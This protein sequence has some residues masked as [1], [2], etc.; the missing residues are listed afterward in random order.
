MKRKIKLD[1]KV[2]VIVINRISKYKIL[3]LNLKINNNNSSN[4][5]SR[6][7]NSSSNNNICKNKNR[8]LKSQKQK[9]F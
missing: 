4:K 3:I 1:N 6:N 8:D 9:I 5:Y 2:I 7:N